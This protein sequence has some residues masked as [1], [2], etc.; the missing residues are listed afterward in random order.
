MLAIP[1]LLPMVPLSEVGTEFELPQRED[2]LF[3]PPASDVFTIKKAT[4]AEETVKRAIESRPR[5]VVS[6]F[7]YESFNRVSLANFNR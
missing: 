7:H 3:S 1:S 2:V 4:E 5:R 6:F